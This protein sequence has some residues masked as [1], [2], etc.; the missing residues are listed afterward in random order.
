MD[1]PTVYFDIES[2]RYVVYGGKTEE[3]SLGL[4]RVIVKCVKHHVLSSLY[5]MGIEIPVCTT[6]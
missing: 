3:I 6:G 1:T 5:S 2:N 4:A